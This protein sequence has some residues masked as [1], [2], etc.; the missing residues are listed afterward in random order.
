MTMR[1]GGNRLESPTDTQK[2][3]ECWLVFPNMRVPASAPPALGM[4]LYLPEL[5]SENLPLH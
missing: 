3:E 4:Q 2:V 1:R 5:S